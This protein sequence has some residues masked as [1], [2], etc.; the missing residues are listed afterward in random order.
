MTKKFVYISVFVLIVSGIISCE[1]DFKDIATNVVSNTKFE[2]KD[3]IIEIEVTN[4]QIQNIR[5]DGLSIGGSL[6]QYLLGVY[7]N[8]NYEKIEASVVSQLAIDTNLSE[9]DD[10][11]RTY[12]ADT[13]VVTTIDTVF[14]KIPYQATLKEETTSDYTLD[15]IIGDKTKAF[16]FNLYRTD[17]Y[18]NRLDPVDPSKTNKFYSDDTYQI[19]PGELNA[20]VDYPFKPNEKDTIFVF[21]RRFSNGHVYKVD[22]FKLAANN[23]FARIPLD[24]NKI[25]QLFVDQFESQYFKTQDDLNEY[26]KGL[27]LEAKGNEGSLMSFNLTTNNLELKPSI[28][29]RYTKTV[30]KGGSQVV[31]TIAKSSSFPLSNFSNSLYKM[32]EKA[33]PNNGNIILQGAAGNMAIVK[34]FDANNLNALKN[35]EWLVNDAKLTFYVNQNIVGF[36]TIST[37]YKLFVYKEGSSSQIKDILS[38]GITAFNGRLVKKDKKPDYYSFTITD[39]ISDLFSGKIKYNPNLRLKVF[40]SS[41]VP[42]NATDTIVRQYSWNPKVV[43]LLNHFQ[44]NGTRRAQLKISYSVKK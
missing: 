22:T 25:K 39:Y 34:L 23:P 20:Q 28:E 19:L 44:A 27:Y 37:P 31:D 10:K 17:T 38:E 11:E 5:T 8:P 43:T 24:K 29:I 13:T 41:D 36:D 18:M 40:N 9:K 6:G 2:T 7:N 33:F 21:K 1:K 12:G 3:T 14:F 16:L 32:N 26:I 4:K 42:P 15:S 30:L 35:K